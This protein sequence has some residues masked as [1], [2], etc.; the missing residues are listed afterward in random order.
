MVYIIP[1]NS[2]PKM[3]FDFFIILASIAYCTRIIFVITFHDSDFEEVFVLQLANHTLTGVYI[4]YMI[5]NF[6]QAYQDDSTGEIVSNPKLIAWHYLT[7]WFA[8]D[9]ISSL[10]FEAFQQKYMSLLRLI[11]INKIFQFFTFVSRVNYKLRGTIRL[12]RLAFTGVFGTFLFSCA[13][14]WICYRFRCYNEHN[15]YNE[16]MNHTK[17]ENNTIN[18]TNTER[19]YFAYL[20]YC[21][22]FV[23][24]T[25]TTTGFGD[26]VPQNSLERFFAILLMLFGVLFF[27]Y[28]LSLISEEISSDGD[29]QHIQSQK[30]ITDLRKINIGK[31]S[32]FFNE[33]INKT[34]LDNVHFATIKSRNDPT[35]S[36]YNCEILPHE[37]K[38]KL[39][40]YLWND[41]FEQICDYFGILET[42]IYGKFLYK[43]SYHF[44]YKYFKPKDII[45]HPAYDLSDVFIIQKGYVDIDNPLSRLKKRI[46]PADIIGHFYALFHVKPQYIYSAVSNVEAISIDK[47]KF[48]ELVR[49]YEKVYKMVSKSSVSKFRDV[50]NVIS[51]SKGVIKKK[52]VIPDYLF[53]NEKNEEKK[54]RDDQEY[55]KDYKDLKK[56]M[57]GIV[58][59][60]KILFNECMANGALM[61]QYINSFVL[62]RKIVDKL[63]GKRLNKIFI[64]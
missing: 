10:P 54:D 55:V 21:Y 35:L 11:R 60:D 57:N 1:V 37:I 25:L 59:N 53:K 22:Y 18:Y 26:Y 36:K 32:H 42:N 46:N 23:L 52:K 39:T 48:N 51:N 24:T 41:I 5:T 28:L 58:N 34:I 56:T 16:Y 43:L 12:L 40:K 3:I 2:K 4:I 44:Q 8:I 29:N 33:K 50:L 49:K 31:R 38:Q 30:L 20:L 6:L 17:T 62:E 45:Y 13:W 61:G 63:E 15:F 27:S 19:D 14:F 7:G 9:F 64:I 47:N